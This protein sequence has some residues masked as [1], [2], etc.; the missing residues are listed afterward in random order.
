MSRFL[1]CAAFLALLAAPVAARAADAADGPTVMLRLQSVDKI[2]D[3]AEYI[4]ALVGQE[5]AAKQVLGFVRALSGEKGIEGIDTKRGFALYANLA[6]KLEESQLVLM[7]P[8]ADQ[9][10]FVNLLKTK[11]K[12]FLQLELKEEKGGLY[13]IAAP[14]APFPIYFRFANKYVYGT[15]QNRDNIDPKKL[16]K[17]EDV[18]GKGDSLID[19]TFRVDRVPEMMKQFALAGLES[20][21]GEAKKQPLPLDTQQTRLLRDEFVDSV[22][23]GL[24]SILTD[25][26]GISLKIDIDPKKDELALAFEMTAKDGSDLAKDFAA[27]KTKKSVAL[28]SLASSKAAAML[29]LNLSLPDS[30]KK[31]LGPVVDDAVKAGLDMAPGEIQ[32]AVE[33]LVKALIPTLKAGDL[34]LGVAMLGPDAKSHYTLLLAGKIKDGKTVEKEVKALVGKLPEPIKSAFEIDADTVGGTKIH[35]V[36]VKDQLDDKAKKIFGDTDLWLAF[37][38]DAILVAFGP[39]AKAALK[40]ALGQKPATGPLVKVEVSVQRLVA[41]AEAGD[42]KAARKAAKEAFGS[43]AAGDTI[44]VALEGGEKLSFRAAMKGKVLKFFVL[45]DKAKKG[46]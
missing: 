12:D 35:S 40:D 45:L 22:S 24:K 2:L 5:D 4:A 38:D 43:D 39:E 27:I 37:R 26:K 13:S 46:D 42:E 28:G 29:A 15:I 1:A 33:P 7:I 10:A 31:V 16:P 34:D 19:L 44:T 23:R 14:A 8:V 18:V 11:G 36:K 41:L 17:P 25:G 6:E 9:D 3:N 21:I 30:V 32:T 20:G